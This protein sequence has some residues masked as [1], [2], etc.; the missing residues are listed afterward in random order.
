MISPGDVPCLSCQRGYNTQHE[1]DIPEYCPCDRARNH[2]RPARE[3]LEGLVER[4]KA[5]NARSQEVPADVDD[6]DA[7]VEWAAI[8]IGY[9]IGETDVL[10]F[11]GR[12]IPPR[13]TQILE[14][15]FWGEGR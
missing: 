10:D 6:L 4:N 11:Q 9:L 1:C 7:H 15:A 5:D 2:T 3:Y 14:R 13:L 8:L 12:P